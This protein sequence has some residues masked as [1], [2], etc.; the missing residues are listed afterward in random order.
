M[1]ALRV[2]VTVAALAAWS[3]A[4][5]QDYPSKPVRVVVPY[6]AGGG[7][8]MMCRTVTQKVADALHQPFV[9]ENK[10]G[11]AGTIGASFVAHAAPDGYTIM[12][13]NNSEVTLAQFI[14]AGLPYDPA[15]DLAPI[16]MAVRQT[17]VL[18]AN[19]SVPAQDMKQLL[20]LTRK[21]PVTY[22]TSGIGS[23]LHLAMEMFAAN[24]HA[25]FVHVPYK[26]AAGLVV[27]TLSGQVQLA[28][29]NLAPVIG[30]IH[31]KKLRPLMVFQDTRNP[32]VPDVPTAKEVI[33]IDVFA[34]SWFGFTA[35]AKTPT[36]LVA[37]LDAAIRQALSEASV[38]AKLAQVD[39]QIV[40]MPAA[41]FGVAIG[42]ERAMNARLVKQ[43]GIKPE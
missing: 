28:V 24:A 12:C 8:D 13:G 6:Q 34:P 7:L 19:P 35:P 38:R 25:P 14:I 30:Y 3:Y 4:G 16:T 2:V 27:D 36:P 17:L 11:A 23:N 43:F 20:E 10:V 32:A 39:M 37:K 26:G 18:V 29:I 42:S 22:A 41:D 9:I 5:A 21:Q 15:R 40:G 1:N 33:G 31:D